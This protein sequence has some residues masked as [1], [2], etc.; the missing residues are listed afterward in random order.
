MRKIKICSA[1]GRSKIKMCIFKLNKWGCFSILRIFFILT[2]EKRVHFP[3]HSWLYV[4]PFPWSFIHQYMVIG[5]IFEQYSAGAGQPESRMFLKASL[6]IWTG[7]FISRE[8]ASLGSGFTIWA[9]SLSG[10]SRWQ[11]PCEINP[12]K[13]KNRKRRRKS[14]KWWVKPQAAVDK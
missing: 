13:S 11:G 1:K 6:H 7:A 12:W 10:W 5:L 3:A 9:V 14:D 2:P 8:K 4:H